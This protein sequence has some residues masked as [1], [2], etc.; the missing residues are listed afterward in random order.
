MRTHARP[1]ILCS[2]C[3]G[4]EACRYNGEAI[5]DRFTMLLGNHAEMITVCPEA[6]AAGNSPGGIKTDRRKRGDYR[7]SAVIRA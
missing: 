5:H 1:V 7:L 6:A 4:T 3:L 2:A